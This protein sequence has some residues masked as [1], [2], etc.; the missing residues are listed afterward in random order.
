MRSSPSEEIAVHVNVP[1]K[2]S[3]PRNLLATVNQSTVVLAWRNTFEGGTPAI[4]TLQVSGG[5]ATAIPLGS[6]E[7]ASFGGVPAGTYTLSVTS[8]NGAGTSDPSNSVVV[9]V[10]GACSGVPQTPTDFLADRAGRTIFVEWQLPTTGAAPSDYL[11][12]VTGAVTTTLPMPVRAISG[13][14]GPGTYHLSIAARN[15]CG[16]SLSTASQ[17]VVVP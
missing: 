6:V 17:T 7:R 9:T 14:V 11:L 5:A 15:A 1:V 2:P 3:P 12:N 10:P 16:T 13:A 4:A 8:S